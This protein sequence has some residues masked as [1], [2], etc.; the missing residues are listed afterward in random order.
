MVPQFA[1][2]VGH[3]D[4]LAAHAASHRQ[5]SEALAWL[6]PANDHGSVA[7]E[8]LRIEVTRRKDSWFRF[9]IDFVSGLSANSGEEYVSR[10]PE[11]AIYNSSGERRVVKITDTEEEAQ[12]FAAALAQDRRQMTILD[13]CERYGVPPSFVGT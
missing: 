5:P 7:T 13:W 8:E 9:L 11:V 10:Y 1:G 2:S 3:S 12:E 6:P 4:P